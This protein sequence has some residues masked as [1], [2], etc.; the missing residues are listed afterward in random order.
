MTRS[1]EE[2]IQLYSIF[3]ED[4]DGRCPGCNPMGVAGAM[5]HEDSAKAKAECL[6]GVATSEVGATIAGVDQK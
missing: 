4:M 3:C 5:Q 2:F 6:F 1:K